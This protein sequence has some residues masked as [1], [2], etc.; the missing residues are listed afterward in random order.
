MH[1][2]GIYKEAGREQLT[3]QPGVVQDALLIMNK[4]LLIE[5]GYWKSSFSLLFLKAFD[6]LSSAGYK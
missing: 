1:A 2:T 3:D 4:R 6:P 5:V